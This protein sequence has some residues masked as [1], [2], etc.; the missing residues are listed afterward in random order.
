M[1][2]RPP[3]ST[4]SRSSAASDVY[5]R[6]GYHHFGGN[7]RQLIEHGEGGI[8]ISGPYVASIDHAGHQDFVAQTTGG[9]QEAELFRAPAEVEAHTFHR[10][11]GQNREGG[12]NAAEVSGDHLSLI[13]I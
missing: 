7:V 3:R 12:T 5:K 2:R 4:Q 13:H 10:E 9:L 11:I 8:E 6:Q 1:I